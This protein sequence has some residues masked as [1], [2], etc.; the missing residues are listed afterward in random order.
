M[1]NTNVGYCKC[2]YEV[3]VE[4]LYSEKRW[5][6]RFLDNDHN[7]ITHCPLCNK[8]LIEDELDSM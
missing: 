8:E 6:C 1:V 3:W 4:Y 7:E 2:G 5:S